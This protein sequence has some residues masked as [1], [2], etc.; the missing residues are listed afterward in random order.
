MA[1][2]HNKVIVLMNVYDSRKTMLKRR[3][4]QQ[5]ANSYQPKQE[6]EQCTGI[7][8]LLRR[9]T[10][11]IAGSFILLIVSIFS[12]AVLAQDDSGIDLTPPTL[13]DFDAAEVSEIDLESYPILPEISDHAR[14]IWAAGQAAGRNPQT[15]T[16]AGDSMSFSRYFLVPFGSE[17]YDMGEYSDLQGVVDHFSAVTFRDSEYNSFNNLSLATGE[18]FSTATV[19]DPFWA[20]PSLCEANESPLACEFRLSNPSIALIMFGTND[21]LFLEAEAFDFYLRTVIW[22]TIEA[23]ILPVMSTIPPRP[24]EPEKSLLFNQII[25]QIAQD[26]DLPLVNLWLAVKPLEDF[27]VDPAETNHLT[28]PADGNSGIL[29]EAHLTAGYTVRN[30]VTLQMLD[31]MLKAVE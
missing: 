11:I 13:G 4:E 16:K 17:G 10:W 5:S 22:Q 23:H 19:L 28:K 30:L 31:R 8:I 18:G 25:V 14:T 6:Q 3:S 27:G 9:H 15:F 20:D 12:P 29:D 1:D 2:Y 24:E 21:V 7:F 26:Y